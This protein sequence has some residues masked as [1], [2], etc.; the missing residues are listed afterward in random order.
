M[1]LMVRQRSFDFVLWLIVCRYVFQSSDCFW[2]IAVVIL[3]FRV[4]IFWMS[5]FEGFVSRLSV[6]RV[7]ISWCMDSVKL[8]LC[9]RREP[10]G[11]WALLAEVITALNAF[12][13]WSIVGKDAGL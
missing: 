3:V 9:V 2:R 1:P 13:A 6:L 10:V 5:S 4:L 8:G 12:T 7:L 11:M